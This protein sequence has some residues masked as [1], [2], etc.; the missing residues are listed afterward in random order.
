MD[1]LL[2]WD[3]LVCI[4]GIF[5]LV[6]TGLATRYFWHHRKN[7]M[8]RAIFIDMVAEFGA[9]VCTLI[10]TVDAV[11]PQW[12]MPTQMHGVLRVLIFSTL[13]FSSLHLAHQTRR[14]IEK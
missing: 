8:G 9:G 1:N 12:D 14:V 11:I 10:F 4:L 6:A 7:P 5:C 13:L 2:F 3:T